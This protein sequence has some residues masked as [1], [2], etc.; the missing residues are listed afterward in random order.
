MGITTELGEQAGPHPQ[1][2]R[3]AGVFQAVI[4][5]SYGLAWPRVG[6]GSR[7]WPCPWLGL[8]SSSLWCPP[9]TPSLV[10]VHTQAICAGHGAWS[11]W[12]L[13]AELQG[14]ARSSLLLLLHSMAVLGPTSPSLQPAG[15]NHLLG[16]DFSKPPRVC[17][18]STRFQHHV[19]LGHGDRCLWNLLGTGRKI[20]FLSHFVCFEPSSD[21]T[22]CH[23]QRKLQAL[24]YGPLKTM[25]K[26]LKP[27]LYWTQLLGR[28]G[29]RLY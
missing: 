13:Q 14:A 7:E 2:P 8:P 19:Q 24:E 25:S 26:C 10:A 3:V 16:K 15:P 1:K 22:L 9:A 27:P 29:I 21:L 6:R 23:T 4:P 12:D 28:R 5:H 18:S 20:G 17:Q 11:S